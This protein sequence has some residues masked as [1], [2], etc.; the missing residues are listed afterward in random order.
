MTRP[1]PRGA[2]SDVA[3]RW[4]RPGQFDTADDWKSAG[5]KPVPNHVV[6]PHDGSAPEPNLADRQSPG[7][8]A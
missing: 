4:D 7:K 6:N 8:A 3:E 2:L 1:K 5:I